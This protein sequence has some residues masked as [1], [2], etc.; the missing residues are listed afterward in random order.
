MY[1]AST[2]VKVSFE[3]VRGR[4]R[5]ER[6]A[7][8]P[9]EPGLHLRGLNDCEARSERERWHGQPHLAW[10]RTRCKETDYIP[11]QRGKERSQYLLVARL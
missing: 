11:L 8:D 10:G 9:R 4:K 3:Q 5:V 1:L 6:D 7:P 2:I